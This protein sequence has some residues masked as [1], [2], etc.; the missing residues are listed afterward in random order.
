MSELAFN[1]V[2]LEKNNQVLSI[3]SLASIAI[4]LILVI[5]L[6]FAF[7]K[8]PLI[9]FEDSGQVT[10]LK[11]QGFKL[12]EKVLESFVKLIA[13][14]YLSFSPTSLPLQI[15]GIAPYLTDDPKRAILDSYKKNEKRLQRGSVFHQFTIHDINITKKNSPFTVEVSGI[16]TIYANGKNKNTEAAYVFAV[17]KI[18]Q[19]ETNPYGLIVSR[20]VEKPKDKS[21]VKR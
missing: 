8:T 5:M 4:N 12:N 15:Q 14:E 19:T 6:I 3:L 20:I 17:Q 10:A 18:K 16:R 9:V 7:N 1:R 21:E 13:K 2:I 11:K